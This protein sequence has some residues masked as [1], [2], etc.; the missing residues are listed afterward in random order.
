MCHFILICEETLCEHAEPD[1]GISF[2]QAAGKAKGA[3]AKAKESA[4]PNG[5]AARVLADMQSLEYEANMKE[6]GARGYG[7]LYAVFGGGREGLHACAAGMRPLCLLRRRPPFSFAWAC[8]LEALENNLHL[9]AGH[10]CQGSGGSRLIAMACDSI[11][12]GAMLFRQCR[13]VGWKGTGAE[14]WKIP[15]ENDNNLCLL[16]C[17]GCAV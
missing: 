17:S 12:R 10:A 1:S 3:A 8:S 13:P 9:A 2:E 4:A 15:E 16:Y 14:V 5:A 11:C 7:K 6:A